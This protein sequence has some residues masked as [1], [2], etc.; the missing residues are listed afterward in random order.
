[1]I[2]TET[3]GALICKDINR[4]FY[5]LL[6]IARAVW[7]DASQMQKE[8]NAINLQLILILILIVYVV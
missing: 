1:M 6:I 5:T 2:V 8:K 3:V 4:L 7:T